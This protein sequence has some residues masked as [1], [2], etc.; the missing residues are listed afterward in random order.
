MVLYVYVRIYI[1]CVCM[2]VYAC[3]YVC[4]YV[5]MYFYVYVCMC[6][7]LCPSVCLSVCLCL[8]ATVFLCLSFSVC[9]C[10]PA[11]VFLCPSVLRPGYF[12]KHMQKETE[13]LN[14]PA[15][16]RLAQTCGPACPKT[17]FARYLEE[18]VVTRI[19]PFKPT[20]RAKITKPEDKSK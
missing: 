14:P 10:L 13:L 1:I 20:L 12:S 6:V 3:M 4:T 18:A 15:Q 11:S 2:Y 8:P 19:R 17:W 5:C 9:L 16:T 7:C